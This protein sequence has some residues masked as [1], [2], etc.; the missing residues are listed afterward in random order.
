[1][2]KYEKLLQS[3]IDNWKYV[4]GLS[5]ADIKDIMAKYDILASALLPTS[6]STYSQDVAQ[7][8]ITKN[9]KTFRTLLNKE[10]YYSI[11]L[12]ARSKS[13]ILSNDALNTVYTRVGGTSKKLYVQLLNSYTKLNNG[14]NDVYSD[15][16]PDKF[17]ESLALFG[18]KRVDNSDDLDDQLNAAEMS[19]EDLEAFGV[20]AD[21]D[22]ISKKLD[23]TQQALDADDDDDGD[24]ETAEDFNKPFSLDDFDNLETEENSG[25]TKEFEENTSADDENFGNLEDEKDAAAHV[26]EDTGNDA[27][28]EID[29]SEDDSSKT[30]ETNA[31]NEDEIRKRVEEAER[32]KEELKKIEEKQRENGEYTGGINEDDIVRNKI[33]NSDIYKAGFLYDDSA[34]INSVNN[35]IDRL[36]DMYANLYTDLP[37]GVL[38]PYGD[39]GNPKAIY[40]QLNSKEKI[41][42]QNTVETDVRRTMN[43][44]CNKIYRIIKDLDNTLKPVP[45]KYTDKAKDLQVN[46]EWM[47]PDGTMIYNYWPVMQA[48]IAF[49]VY[50]VEEG[51]GISPELV[52]KFVRANS[53]TEYVQYFRNKITIAIKMFLTRLKA[54]SEDEWADLID[55]ALG[56][57]EAFYTNSILINKIDTEAFRYAVCLSGFNNPKS[58]KSY[59]SISEA[60]KN[61][62]LFHIGSPSKYLIA[63]DKEKDGAYSGL[64]VLN[65]ERFIGSVG[66][67]YKTVG[68]AVMHG[69]KISLDNAIIGQT[70]SGETRGISLNDNSCTVLG[71]IAASRSGK[72]VLTLSLLAQ[73]LAC[74][75]P[76]CYI[77]F[78]PDM[79]KLFWDLSNKYNV[80]VYA[81]DASTNMPGVDKKTKQPKK[82]PYPYTFGNS[83]NNKLLNDMA[84]YTKVSSMNASN[85]RKAFQFIPYVK[86]IYLMKAIATARMGNRGEELKTGS[87]KI[88]FVFDEL[89]SLSAE[90]ASVIDGLCSVSK[91]KTAGKPI[92]NGTKNNPPLLP[93]SLV[94]GLADSIYTY[95]RDAP[96]ALETFR[97]QASG[98]G[99]VTAI[100][101]AQNA[102][103]TEIKGPFAKTMLNRA[104]ALLGKGTVKDSS[105]GIRPNIDLENKEL[106][107]NR[108]V[109]AYCTAPTVTGNSDTTV[110]KTSMVL[111]DADWDP[112]PNKVGEYTDGLLH[113]MKNKDD[114]GLSKQLQDYTINHD[115]IVSEDNEVALDYG[116]KVGNI[117][118]LIGFPGYLD[119]LMKHTSESTDF[120]GNPLTIQ[121]A[122]SSGHRICTKFLKAIGIIST[123]HYASLEDWLFSIDPDSLVNA[124]IMANTFNDHKSVYDN[125]TS[126][127]S[128]SNIYS[129]EMIELKGSA[130]AYAGSND[131]EQDGTEQDDR[132]SDA[133]IY[134]AAENFMLQVEQ[135]INQTAREPLRTNLI[136]IIVETFRDWGI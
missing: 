127:T 122:L 57:I 81:I 54:N 67:A 44:Q 4:Q 98:S 124:D 87:N 51:K 110:I 55:I 10:Y 13:E 8:I 42:G 73:M 16:T 86:S 92:F 116:C 97:N 129:D 27:D 22:E 85:L 106:L 28:D 38:G 6:S 99:K 118:P 63:G 114:P 52:G 134:E 133:E 59:R 56:S 3:T 75:A 7:D 32:A 109:F 39:D 88:Y 2:N 12:T 21:Q 26:E 18:L 66:F 36:R 111:N 19:K 108:G 94:P 62:D 46:E 125:M 1:M 119:Y 23:E 126:G 95:F 14:V 113:G 128:D 76:V 74:G 91:D 79:A 17:K 103:A 11:M 132:M 64:I 45:Y 50:K 77:D 41:A 53:W 105:Y 120:E 100:V 84:A 104:C 48:R 102:M 68:K 107:N 43:I 89:Q 70:F 130:N 35:I 9:K 60:I 33:K 49:G 30:A 90:I 29:I 47:R 34:I 72:G 40:I 131:T 25:E 83:H 93:D 136:K 37:F 80:P 82:R 31:S 112:D 117:N 101:F 58:L 65:K 123:G 20:F 96:N 121:T 24:G 69:A 5:D 115:F 135:S 15:I 78:K 71:I 61:S